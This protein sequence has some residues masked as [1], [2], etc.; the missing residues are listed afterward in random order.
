MN[1]Y[2]IAQQNIGDLFEE[3]N[4]GDSLG[5]RIFESQG[6]WLY[7]FKNVKRDNIEGWYID[8]FDN[9]GSIH[10]IE[11]VNIGDKVADFSLNMTPYW[12]VNGVDSDR[13][14][15]YLTPIEPN[16]FIT[17]VGAGGAKI[18]EHDLQVHTGEY[19]RK[20]IDGVLDVINQKL[21]AS[22]S[23]IAY[24]LQG[25]VPVNFGPNG[26]QGGWYCV[27]DTWNNRGGKNGLDAQHI[28][29]SDAKTLQQKFGFTIPQ[30][31]LDGSMDVH[32]WGFFVNGVS[33]PDTDFQAEN[34]NYTNVETSKKYL[35]EAIEP[36]RKE[37]NLS[38]IIKKIDF[39][40][41]PTREKEKL[42]R[43]LAV[44]IFHMYHPTID[45]RKFDVYWHLKEQF[46]LIAQRFKW[47]D[48]LELYKKCY[49]STN[50]AYV[51]SAYRFLSEEGDDEEKEK[52]K[53]SL[54]EMERKEEHPEALYG[55]LR[56]IGEIGIDVKKLYR[57]NKEK[58][59]VIFRKY[60][61]GPYSYY[62][63]NIINTLG[64]K[65]V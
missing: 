50:R 30:K 62:V 45:R 29:M 40:N 60:K 35:S 42:L 8:W 1:W 25:T 51:A 53:K 56:S 64:L 48:I 54:L 58:Y 2:K 37:R 23:D 41:K 18:T 57:Q 9:P 59:D 20:R 15:I 44:D 52:S 38:A 10:E 16:P 3:E 31:A 33:D 34:E 28:M 24:I 46:I 14:T 47:W 21:Y 65:S 36:K 17:G 63:D 26:A 5:E 12:E 27:H 32:K 11:K 4:Y 61:D 49:D 22:P 7:P 55:I 43:D 39:Y 19:E 13:G 6:V